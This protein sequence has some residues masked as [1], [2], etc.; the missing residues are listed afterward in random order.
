MTRPKT[1]ALFPAK[2]HDHGHCVADALEKA[3]AICAARGARLTKIRRR[4]LDIVWES[5]VP[6]GAYDILEFGSAAGK[7]DA[8][9]ALAAFYEAHG[10]AAEAQRYR[11][12]AAAAASL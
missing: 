4:V 3:E 5:H 1:P 6:L 12:E 8:A 7:R 11:D 9:Q 10:R 2:E